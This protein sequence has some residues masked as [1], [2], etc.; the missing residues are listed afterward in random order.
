MGETAFSLSAIQ[1]HHITPALPIILGGLLSA[2]MPIAG[3]RKLIGLLAPALALTLWLSAQTGSYG[4][5]VIGEFTLQTLRYDG[6]SRIFG[7]I[8]IIATALN[9]IYGWHDRD[10]GQDACALLYAGAAVGGVFAGDLLTLF[11][12]WELTALA[13]VYLVMARG[14]AEN[15]NAGLRYLAIQV[16]SGVTLLS[17]AVLWAG[18]NGGSFAFGADFATSTSGEPF[19]DP[20]TPGGALILL[21]FGI[22]AAFPLL[23]NWV[24]DSYPRASSVG[25]VVL[26]AFTTKLAIYALAR[27]FA[28]YEPLIYAGA[29][30]AVFPVFFAAVENDLRRVLAYSLNSQLG[31]MVVGVG[32]GTELALNGAAAHAFVSVLYKGLLFMAMGAVLLRTSTVNANQLG[33]LFKT[34]PFTTVFCAVGAAAISA[35]PL[36]S[37]FVSK[38]MILTAAAKEHHELV[39][40]MLLFAAVGAVH[41]A[42]LKVPYRA[43]FDRDSQRR[44]KEAPFNMLLAMGIAAFLSIYLALPLPQ[45]WGGMSAF[46]RLLPFDIGYDAYTVSHVLAQIQLL[47]AAAFAFAMMLRFRLYPQERPATILDTDWVY[48]RLGYGF[49]IWAAAITGQLW[50]GAMSGIGLAGDV[51]ARRIHAAFAPAGAVNRMISDGAAAMWTGVLL[52]VTLLAAL[53][54]A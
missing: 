21:A 38:A 1:W 33:G 31:F 34:M 16:L 35:F 25:A 5:L 6:L 2:A 24:Q 3:L 13:S 41:N 23:H 8:F 48:R 11:V 22:K 29:I 36:F 28:G 37:G 43:F 27:G 26:S 39:W 32:I 30:M 7:L 15:I 52:A 40:A 42:G 10:R 53:F 54:A 18:A 49:V 19:F 14:G 20:S 12:F 17:G 4:A 51:L 45:G 9:S 46:Y 50:S 44:P 47:A